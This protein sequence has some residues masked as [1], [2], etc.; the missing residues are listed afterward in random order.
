M[1]PV[2]IYIT[3]GIITDGGP[4]KDYNME[5]TSPSTI[6]LSYN[7]DSWFGSKCNSFKEVHPSYCNGVLLAI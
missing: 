3:N 4:L 6:Y 1:L 2:V 7:L 5:S